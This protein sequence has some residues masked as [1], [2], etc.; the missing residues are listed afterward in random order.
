MD[1]HRLHDAPTGRLLAVA[2]HV[3]VRRWSQYLQEKYGL[4]PAGITVLFTL[5]KEGP[6]G[7]REMAERCFIRPATLTGVVDT[8][9]K[10]GYVERNRCAAPDRR[11]VLLGLTE[12]GQATAKLLAEQVQSDTPLTSVD[13][14][15][16][17]RAVIRAFLLEI[18]DTLG[19]GEDES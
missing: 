12:S 3:A 13:V 11:A 6:L 9:E 7:H 16:A 8:L 5:H 18:I 2:G 4:T 15:P 10:S 1:T 19:T 14:D 17:N